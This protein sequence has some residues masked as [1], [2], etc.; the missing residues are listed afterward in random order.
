MT[1]RN[2]ND[3]LRQEVSSLKSQVQ[4][5]NNIVWV[6]GIVAVVFGIGGGWGAKT[7]F[8]AQKKLED[9]KSGTNQYLKEVD[10]HLNEKK[11]ALV[12]ELDR[13]SD[14]KKNELLELKA[15]ALAG[16]A[17]TSDLG[18]YVKY[19]ESIAL[20]LPAHRNVLLSGSLDKRIGVRTNTTDAGPD[21]RWKIIRPPT[22][23]R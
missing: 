15:S 22:A 2:P 5:L 18:G 7:L 23:S 3:E 17:K 4:R 14:K 8:E 19:D 6:I 12:S 21:E 11:D 16:Y 20:Q 13:H 10:K 9:F 1:Q